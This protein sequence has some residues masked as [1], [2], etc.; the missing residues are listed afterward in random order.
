MCVLAG[1]SLYVCVCVYISVQVE[2]EFALTETQRQTHHVRFFATS[3][4]DPNSV[5]AALQYA[6]DTQVHPPP[7]V[8]FR[9]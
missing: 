2:K 5:M 9:W 1:C 3:A 7:A 4:T 6:K 8:G